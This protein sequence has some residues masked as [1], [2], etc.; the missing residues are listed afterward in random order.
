VSSRA[1]AK[2]QLKPTADTSDISVASVF[3]SAASY[4]DLLRVFEDHNNE[5]ASKDKV[6]GIRIVLSQDQLMSWC[7]GKA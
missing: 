6:E 4:H 1:I 2:F 5:Q 7:V 3:V